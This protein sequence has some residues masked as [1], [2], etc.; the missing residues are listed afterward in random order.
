M[1]SDL[2][3]YKCQHFLTADILGTTIIQHILK[4]TLFILRNDYFGNKGI[5]ILFPDICTMWLNLVKVCNGI[6]I[7]HIESKHQ[8][9]LR[10]E[11]TVTLSYCKT[12]KNKDER[13]D[14][15]KKLVNYV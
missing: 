8:W 10:A 7:F 1:L 11:K 15:L 12:G 9:A 14:S 2:L 13:A 4:N 5:V 6:E 3:H